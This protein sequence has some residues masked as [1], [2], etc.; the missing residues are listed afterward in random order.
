MCAPVRLY[1]ARSSNNNNK[2]SPP[3]QPDMPSSPLS[4][5]RLP[6]P[7]LNDTAAASTPTKQQQQQHATHAPP[8]G[9]Q[10]LP[11][12]APDGSLLNSMQQPLQLHGSVFGRSSVSLLNDGVPSLSCDMLMD[13]PRAQQQQPQQ[14]GAA[15]PTSSGGSLS[16]FEA[17]HRSNEPKR[18]AATGN[19]NSSS[20][21]NHPFAAVAAAHAAPASSG[22][23]SVSNAATPHGHTP[24]TS[25]NGSSSTSMLMGAPSGSMQALAEM[26]ALHLDRSA[27]M[28]QQQQQQPQQQQ[29][30]AGMMSAATPGA[31]GVS[32]GSFAP[33]QQGPGGGQA[34]HQQ[35]LMQ[36]PGGGVVQVQVPYGQGLPAGMAGI[37]LASGPHGAGPHHTQVLSFGGPQQLPMQ[38]A[39][40]QPMQPMQQIAMP[41]AVQTQFAGGAPMAFQVQPGT[42]GTAGGFMTVTYSLPNGQVLQ[43][44]AAGQPGMMAAVPM[45]AGQAQGGFAPM[46]Q[47][48]VGGPTANGFFLAPA[49]AT[50]AGPAG[51]GPADGAMW[52]QQMQGAAGVGVSA[53]TAVAATV[54]L[55]Y[56]DSCS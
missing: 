43:G 48:A 25:M 12:I 13:P 23:S 3:P 38:G 39:A 37:T 33:Q 1:H 46:Q 49:G 44:V 18:P 10:S 41:M 55:A 35:V 27:S 50:V 26:Q 16:L 34:G 9:R 4:M 17:R 52:W 47:V 28:T 21:P 5:P 53:C 45:A 14:Q 36:L 15:K 42:A 6:S 56:T 20:T 40:V 19:G 29:Q 31:G 32:M 7:D 2:P 54:G 51:C 24:S 11:Q 22:V 30:Q 8:L